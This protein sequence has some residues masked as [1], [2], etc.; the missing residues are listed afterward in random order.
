MLFLVFI[1]IILT[2]EYLPY[3]FNAFR[4]TIVLFSFTSLCGFSFV[5]HC[6]LLC[7]YWCAFPSLVF[8]WYSLLLFILPFRLSVFLSLT[9]KNQTER[10]QYR[11]NNNNSI[12][13]C[14][15]FCHRVSTRVWDVLPRQPLLPAR[16]ARDVLFPPP[17]S[18]CRP[19]PG[20]LCRGDPICR[21]EQRRQTDGRGQSG[22][23]LVIRQWRLLMVSGF[24]SICLK[25]S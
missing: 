15:S 3:L 5:W 22:I 16:P 1:A 23:W 10:W 9:T 14:C 2:I 19:T 25:D 21:G 24:F 13:F 7:F 18:L 4:V 11:T 6:L 12:C 17:G 20:R 8:L